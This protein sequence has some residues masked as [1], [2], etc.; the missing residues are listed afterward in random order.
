[1]TPPR[2]IRS[3]KVTGTAFRRAKRLAE[4]Q[5]RGI[6]F[7]AEAEFFKRDAEAEAEAYPEPEGDDE[8][9]EDDFEA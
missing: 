6:E 7:D 2:I 5:E 8:P 4:M 9:A 1:M 3:Y